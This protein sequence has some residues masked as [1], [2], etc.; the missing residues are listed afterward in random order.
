MV[1]ERI[2]PNFSEQVLLTYGARAM[3]QPDFIPDGRLVHVFHA[4]QCTTIVL[5]THEFGAPSINGVLLSQAMGFVQSELLELRTQVRDGL[6]S[7]ILLSLL[8]FHATTF[9]LPGLYEHPCCSVLAGSLLEA[10]SANERGIQMLPETMRIWLI[11]IGAL[12][13]KG[14]EARIAA[15]RRYCTQAV[16]EGP[17]ETIRQEARKVMW[18]DSIHNEVG[19]AALSMLQA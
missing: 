5:D 2:A 9:R 19:K 3:L 7:L 15:W 11:L 4:L 12:T 16:S 13:A 6:S 17:W 8:A 1:A 18:I 14:D 10:F